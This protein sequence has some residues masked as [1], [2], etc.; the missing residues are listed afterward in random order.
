MVD[1]SYFYP[2]PSNRWKK[3][4]YCSLYLLTVNFQKLCQIHFFL[5]SLVQNFFQL[6]RV[7]LSLQLDTNSCSSVLSRLNSNSFSI[8]CLTEVNGA[9]KRH[10]V[11]DGRLKGGMRIEKIILEIV[12]KC[13]KGNITKL[14]QEFF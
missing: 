2:T 8:S 7:L 5:F 3:P 13:R 10:Q 9:L 6:L 1:I 11:S 14:S 12:A 4:K